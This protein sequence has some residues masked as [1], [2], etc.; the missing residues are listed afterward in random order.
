MTSYSA[1]KKTKDCILSQIFANKRK[2]LKHSVDGWFLIFYFYEVA[3]T[4]CTS[5]NS[6]SLSVICS[7]CVV[8]CQPP[9]SKQSMLNNNDADEREEN[10]KY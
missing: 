9:P 7:S 6:A 5:E 4:F 1:L 3:K 8:T 10:S 2:L